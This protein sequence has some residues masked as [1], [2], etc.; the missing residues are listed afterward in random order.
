MDRRTVLPAL[1]LL[2]I[3]GPLAE[4]LS[5]NVALLTFVQP[6]PF[7]LVTLTYGVPV[8]VIREL[9][10]ARKLNDAGLILLGLAYGILNEG[11]LAK[12]LTLSDGP[13]L[14]DFAGYG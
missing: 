3:P 6:V 7:L 12:T 8:L 2:L 13:P 14:Q 11:V 5:Q 9:A 1:F 4:V 10:V